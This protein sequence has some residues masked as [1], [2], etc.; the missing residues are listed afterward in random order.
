VR[1]N[2]QQL[3]RRTLVR[4]S[5]AAL[6]LV[7]AC[8]ITTDALWSSKLRTYPVAEAATI[9]ALP[10]TIGF[11]DSDLYGLSPGDVD[12]TLDLMRATGVSTVRILMPWAGIQPSQDAFDWGAVDVMVNAAAA[13]GMAVLGVLNSTPGWAVPPGA[14]AITS[15]P[16]SAAAYGD[17]AGAVAAR[18]RGTVSAYEVWNEP[19]SVLFWTSGPSGPSPAGYTDLL[20]AAYPKI[21]AADPSA[22]VVGGVLAS[23]I[24]FFALSTDPV[25]FINGMYAAGAKNYFDA[26]SFH[27][28]QYTTKF[29]DGGSLAN[30]PVNQLTQIRQAMVNNGDAGKKIWATEYG[31]PTS[32]V[33][34]AGQAAYL[35]DMLSKWRTLP[36]AGP[37]FIYT[38]RDRNTG[39]SNPEDTFGVY[40]TDWTA[41]P[42]QQTVRAAAGA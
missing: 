5:V 9:T 40:R 32:A 18:Y 33:D 2:G 20:K 42:A 3:L 27:P 4:F 36:Y 8:A 19:N 34:E 26:L 29:S 22:T 16:A 6:A 17:F 7:L 14:A 25:T 12:R 11:A 38:T 39:S 28:Y 37:V 13:R 35:G 23:V 31:E 15:P 10:T 41:K 30:S 21:K 24:G 1:N